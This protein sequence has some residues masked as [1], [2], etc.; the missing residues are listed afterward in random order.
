MLPE[1]KLQIISLFPLLFSPKDNHINH[2]GQRQQGLDC[3]EYK[4]VQ[5][6]FMEHDNH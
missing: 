4:T 1:Q 6:E 2:Y 3:R 5:A